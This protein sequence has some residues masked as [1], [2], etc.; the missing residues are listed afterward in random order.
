[1]IINSNRKIGNKK[2]INSVAATKPA[3]LNSKLEVRDN[4]I[5]FFKK[6]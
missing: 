3:A 1:M 5:D 4:P 2:T 6:K